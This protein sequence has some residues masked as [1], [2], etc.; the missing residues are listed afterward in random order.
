MQAITSEDFLQ[1]V[2]RK[3]EGKTDQEQYTIA[4]NID[5][6]RI[7]ES[8]EKA[9]QETFFDGR[10]DNRLLNKSTNT[11]QSL[12]SLQKAVANIE[13]F[14]RKNQ[15][16]L[17]QE[18][19]TYLIDWYES[20]FT[21][22][23]EYFSALGNYTLYQK[24]YSKSNKKLLGAQV[25]TPDSDVLWYDLL[26][27]Y[28]SQFDGVDIFNITMTVI[29][30]FYYDITNINIG[31]R[32]FSLQLSPYEGNRVTNIRLL[33][34]TF[35]ENSSEYIFYDEL[36]N[37]T[38]DL[39]VEQAKYEK[40]FSKAKEGEKQQYDFSQMFRRQFF[41]AQKTVGQ[42]YV[43]ENYENKGKDDEV[44]SVFKSAKLL[45]NKW[46]FKILEDVLY[47]TYDDLDVKKFD[48]TF[49]ISILQSELSLFLD[50]PEQSPGYADMSASYELE[51]D[52]HYFFDVKISPYIMQGLNKI[53]LV[54]EN[55]VSFIGNIEL[56]D[57][58]TTMETFFI[59]LLSFT[60]EYE[61]FMSTEPEEWFKITYNV[62][63]EKISIIQNNTTSIQDK[64]QRLREQ[65]KK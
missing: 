46:E 33:D 35:A 55:Q 48:D 32:N 50:D 45:W 60:E 41:P 23:E 58:T 12:A 22:F 14:Y 11:I 2:I 29:D 24:D 59:K 56:Q 53:S 37:I 65:F 52:N 10:G 7:W 28:L 3:A 17:K 44:I 19:Y 47:I 5:H 34:N 13:V 40:L 25:Y 54:W 8:L 16:L 62:E 43:W 30:E 31:G 26:E 15:T 51:W 20:L 64:L 49:S 42:T 36:Q 1:K 27:E 63:N 57:F 9:I 6:L 4:T 61:E 38:L 21:T 18:N 39:D